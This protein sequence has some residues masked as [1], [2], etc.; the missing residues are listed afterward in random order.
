MT[1]MQNMRYVI[2]TGDGVRA[3][4]ASFGGGQRARH[5]EWT[6]WAGC[7]LDAA[8]NRGAEWLM[9]ATLIRAEVALR[10][11]GHPGCG[12]DGDT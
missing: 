8:Q 4:D 1:G 3:A 6:Y 12:R 2:V 9:V 7:S 10:F 11:P 5:D